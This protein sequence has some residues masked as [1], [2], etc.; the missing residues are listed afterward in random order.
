[1]LCGTIGLGA[2]LFFYAEYRLW[3]PLNGSEIQGFRRPNDE[4]LI[5]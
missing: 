5:F 3:L 1:M 2:G 4:N